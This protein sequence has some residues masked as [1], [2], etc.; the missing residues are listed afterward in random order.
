MIETQ[1]LRLRASGLAVAMIPIEI[2]LCAFAKT[3]GDSQC[4]AAF[5]AEFEG[6][7]VLG[8]ALRAL[9][10]EG[11]TALTAEFSAARIFRPAF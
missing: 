7:G 4:S 5:P 6:R 1:T 8:A 2:L 11:I 3:S 9:D 10:G